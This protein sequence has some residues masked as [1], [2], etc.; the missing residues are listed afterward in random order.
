MGIND[1]VLDW[2][3]NFECLSHTHTLDPIGPYFGK[4]LY[5]SEWRVSKYFLIPLEMCQLHI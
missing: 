5:C 1:P 4:T 3:K 2:G